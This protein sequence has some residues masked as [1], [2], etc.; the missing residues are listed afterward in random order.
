[1]WPSLKRPVEPTA[2]EEA[3]ALILL[4]HRAYRALGRGLT[5]SNRGGGHSVFGSHDQRL[6]F[7]SGRGICRKHFMRGWVD[8]MRLQPSP[9]IFSPGC[10]QMGNSRGFGSTVARM[11]CAARSN[12]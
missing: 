4:P 9:M 3:V 12:C 10:E 2:G 1:M 5:I 11:A 6:G 7:K 8:M